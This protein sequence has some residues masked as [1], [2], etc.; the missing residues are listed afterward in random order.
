VG[1]WV[2]GC[3]MC[4][5][6]RAVCGRPSEGGQ[7]QAGAQLVAAARAT[8]CCLLLRTGH[9]LYHWRFSSITFC[10]NRIV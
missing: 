10:T 2:G 9:V 1:G 8:A 5:D 4:E 3:E 6:E 7:W